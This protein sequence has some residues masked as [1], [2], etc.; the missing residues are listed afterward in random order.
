LAKMVNQWSCR[1]LLEPDSITLGLPG[2]QIRFGSHCLAPF[3][4]S[5]AFGQALI[6]WYIPAFTFVLVFIC[7]APF[8][9][10][11]IFPQLPAGL[12]LPSGFCPAFKF[13]LVFMPS[14]L[15]SLGHMLRNPRVDN[16][17]EPLLT[18]AAGRIADLR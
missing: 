8:S 3:F 13:V 1:R 6:H 15:S 10:S 9:P 5:D 4:L 2:L 14:L 11:G 7:L 17:P 16:K 12:P 18:R